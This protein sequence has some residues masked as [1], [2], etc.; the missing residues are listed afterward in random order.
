MNYTRPRGTVDLLDQDIINFRTVESI[1]RTLAELFCYYEIKTPMFESA[2]LFKK[3]V[4]EESDIVTKEIYTFKDKGDR[5]LALRPEGT[6]SAIRAIVESKKLTSTTLLSKFFY[7][8]EMFRYERPQNGRQR[9]F[10]QFGIECVG[11]F[12]EYDEV[13]VIIFAETIL[14]TLKINEYV[15]EINN[16]GSNESRLKYIN[17]LKVY[18]EKYRSE[19]SEDSQRRIDKNP[20]RIL[21]DKIDGEKD[22][23]KNAPLLN[24][25]LTDEEKKYFDKI[26]NLLDLFGIKYTINQKLVRGLDYY[27]GLV[28]EFISKSDNLTAQSTIIGGGRYDSLVKQTGGPDVK[29]IGF[30]MG[31]ERIIIALGENNELFKKALVKAIILP[32]SEKALNYSINLCNAIRLGAGVSC[33]VSNK[34][35]KLDKHYKYVEKFNCENVIIVKDELIKNDIVILK[36]QKD[37]IEKEIKVLDLIE[38]LEV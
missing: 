2:D 22:F 20:L 35:F 5:K 34:T 28:F 4:G 8:G 37:R 9:Q 23:V 16:L 1:V 11:E 32:L 29:G 36:N 10:H 13:E 21:D 15:L 33:N 24:D 18:F 25:F 31:I 3:S 30:G 27:N 19:L 26:T 38:L 14:K 6:A 7:F 12:N 17:A